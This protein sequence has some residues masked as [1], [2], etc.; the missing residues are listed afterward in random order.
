LVGEDGLDLETPIAEAGRR[1]GGMGLLA[2]ALKNDFRLLEEG[3]GGI[4][5]SVS[6]VLS[7]SDGLGFRFSLGVDGWVPE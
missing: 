7:E 6:T 4:C 3:E 5:D 1:G 2:S